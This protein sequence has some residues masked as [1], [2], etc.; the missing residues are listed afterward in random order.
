VKRNCLGFLLLLAG[1]AAAGGWTK[2][3]ADA[4]ATAGAYQDCREMAASAVKTDADIDQDILATR[5]S[6]SQRAGGVR[7]ETQ[8]MQDHTRD[9]A[10]SIVGA[11]M[12][13][14]GF[15]AAR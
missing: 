12:R 13:A 9:R 1:C 11:C 8:A 3:G 6:D 4:A 10:A 7:V 2:P 14:K 5:S 15:V